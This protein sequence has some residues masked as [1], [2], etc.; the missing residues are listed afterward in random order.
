MEGERLTSL[1]RYFCCR[2]VRHRVRLRGQNTVDRVRRGNADP[3][4][5]SELRKVLD[6]DMQR[7]WEHRLE[8]QLYVTQIIPG[9]EHRV[10]IP[11]TDVLAFPLTHNW[12]GTVNLYIQSFIRILRISVEESRW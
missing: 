12:H 9:A 10:S 2:E 5:Q 8:R 6:N 4:N 11:M 1:F 3:S 7:A